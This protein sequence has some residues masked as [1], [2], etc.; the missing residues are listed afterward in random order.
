[1]ES[2]SK[3]LKNISTP[4]RSST[5]TIARYTREKTARHISEKKNFI[6]FLRSIIGTDIIRLY[7]KRYEYARIYL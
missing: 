7:G 2:Y 1:M 6:V 4:P 3:A 5:I